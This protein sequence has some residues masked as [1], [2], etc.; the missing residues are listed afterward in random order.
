MGRIARERRTGLKSLG[1]ASDEIRFRRSIARLCS[2]TSQAESID[3][4]ADEEPKAR[5]SVL[6]VLTKNVWGRI[7]DAAEEHC[8][9]VEAIRGSRIPPLPHRP[10]VAVQPI[11]GL[12]HDRLPV[13]GHVTPLDQRE[14]LVM[15][16]RTEQAVQTLHRRF[17]V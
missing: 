12:L 11:E 4:W 2:G 9:N 16:W 3:E 1:G 8:I 5:R 14:P 7:K 6:R 13:V 15:L 10:Q 17:R